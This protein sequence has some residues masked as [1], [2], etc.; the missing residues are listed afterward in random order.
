MIMS[1][2]DVQRDERQCISP[3]TGKMGARSDWPADATLTIRAGALATSSGN[4][5][6]AS[7]RPPLPRASWGS[8]LLL[9]VRIIG[10]WGLAGPLAALLGV[11]RSA[12]N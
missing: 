6:R 7:S 5:R 1:S 12:R 11:R 2:Y 3:F 9:P 10:E 4:N 8:F